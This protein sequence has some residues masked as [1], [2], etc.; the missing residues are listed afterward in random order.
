MRLIVSS[1]RRA[2]T[3]ASGPTRPS[4][5]NCIQLPS[6]FLFRLIII[7]VSILLPFEA[8]AYQSWQEGPYLTN[9][10]ALEA[11]SYSAVDDPLVVPASSLLTACRADPNA[12]SVELDGSEITLEADGIDDASNANVEIVSASSAQAQCDA[13]LASVCVVPRGLRL[14]MDGNLNVPALKVQGDLVWREDDQVGDEQ[15]LCA[16]YVAVEGEL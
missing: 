7:A 1:S 12:T 16:G 8:R 11:A 13:N 4:V 10:D 3:S 14:I 2:S 9:F 15:Y 5:T 6:P